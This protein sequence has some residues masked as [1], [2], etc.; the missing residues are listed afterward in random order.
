MDLKSHRALR[1][2]G[3]RSVRTVWLEGGDL[4]QEFIDAFPGSHDLAQ[5]YEK[6][7]AKA[8]DTAD[9]LRDDADTV[10]RAEALRVEIQDHKQTLNKIKAQRDALDGKRTGLWNSW[11]KLWEP[12]GIEPLTP[13]EMTAWAGRARE[14]RRKA[15]DQRER[16]VA[17][18]PIT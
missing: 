7:V 3:W 11:L 9:V 1:D 6:S 4:D 10:A 12:L 14:L 18:G 13:R 8:D 15:S 17:W 2:K 5:A 16:R